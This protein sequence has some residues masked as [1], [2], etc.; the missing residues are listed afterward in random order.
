MLQPSWGFMCKSQFTTSLLG[1]PDPGSLSTVL[2]ASGHVSLTCPP[3]RHALAGHPQ[4]PLGPSCHTPS[5]LTTG[6]P[7]AHAL[8]QQHPLLLGFQ[9]VG[10]RHFACIL[11]SHLESQQLAAKCSQT[12]GTLATSPSNAGLF[13]F[14]S[15]RATTRSI[16]MASPPCTSIATSCG[17]S[18]P[19]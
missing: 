1:H 19:T 3:V 10:Q 4:G 11:H 9:R 5:P 7:A 14:T 8:P 13:T 2:L 12:Q 17:A 16:S 18:H 6:I 15:F